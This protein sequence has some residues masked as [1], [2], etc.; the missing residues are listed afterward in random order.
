MT[1]RVAVLG[2]A[3]LF[4][5]QAVPGMAQSQERYKARLA[6]V[7]IDIAMRSTVAGTGS[8]TAVLAGAK[9]TVEGTFDGLVSPATTAA[10]HR[11]P[12]MGVRGP[13]LG[14][15][16]VSKALK[17][18]L[19]GSIDLTPAQVEALKKGQLYLQ[20]SSEKAPDGNLWGWF[21][22]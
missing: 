18:T 10:V 3:A 4:I 12:A 11:G 13:S 19:S 16:T 15:L 1:R 8:A 20:I 21:V 22:R 14:V 17:G 7:P 2:L 6:P 5:L 9:L